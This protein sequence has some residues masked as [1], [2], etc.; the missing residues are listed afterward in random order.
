MNLKVM[1]CVRAPIQKNILA[2]DMDT[3]LAYIE[4]FQFRWIVIVGTAKN[5]GKYLPQNG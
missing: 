2:V 3:L 1:N 4:V 5:V